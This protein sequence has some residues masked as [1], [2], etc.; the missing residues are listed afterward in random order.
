[1]I[2]D[3]VNAYNDLEATYGGG[4]SNH[5]PMAMVALDGLGADEKYILEY[6][7]WYIDKKEIH[8]LPNKAKTTIESIN[9]YLGHKKYYLELKDFYR[10]EIYKYGMDKTLKTYSD[11]LMKG[12][13]GD[14]FH[15]LIRL[16]YGI[17]SFNIEEMACGL[18]YLTDC[19]LDF[20]I[21][22]NQGFPVDPD[23]Q[24]S[25]L[26]KIYAVGNYDIKG[27][28]IVDKMKSVASDERVSNSF[29]RLP[30]VEG[31]KYSLNLLAL[32]LYGGTHD[33]TMLHGFTAT[34]ALKIL[35][36]YLE[37][38]KSAYEYHW[39]HIQ[40]AYFS[41]ACPEIQEIEINEKI[42]SW[43]YI[44]E[45]AIESKD[46]HTHKVIYSLYK[47]YKAFE[48]QSWS[49]LYRQVA[50]ETISLELNNRV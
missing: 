17:S 18:A 48:L 39:L 9:G 50:S 1:M 27:S 40:L 4:L 14:A 43:V 29:G 38:I 33:F 28:L 42:F 12:A 37:D 26:K 35:E 6:A 22:P 32:R 20:N 41:A 2:T 49:E 31:N 5:L 7:K 16:A 36:P 13:S 44:M 46:P 11:Y 24:L 23:E 25:Q 34:H 15:G 10:R 47:S 45:K 21:D 30:E 3:M 19:F 8:T